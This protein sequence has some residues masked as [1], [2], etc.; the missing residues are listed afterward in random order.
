MFKRILSG[1][2]GE[3]EAIMRELRSGDLLLRYKNE[4]PGTLLII[5][6]G[7]RD[8]ATQKGVMLFL[9]LPETQGIFSNQTIP[10]NPQDWGWRHADDANN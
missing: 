9:T 4:D 3:E 5:H 10:S 1:I 7:A 2:L 8:G 6:P